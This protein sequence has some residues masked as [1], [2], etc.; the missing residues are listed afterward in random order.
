MLGRDPVGSTAVGPRPLLFLLGLAAF[1][2]LGTASCSRART[3]TGQ[4]AVA[5]VIDGDTVQLVSGEKVRLI[6]VD[7]PETK[8]PQK[9]V[10]RFGRE[11]NDFT[12]RWPVALVL[13]GARPISSHEER[14][15]YRLACRC[16][17]SSTIR[18]Q[19]PSLTRCAPSNGYG[20]ST[21][22]RRA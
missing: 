18:R 21:P 7:T 12:R 15:A 8:H 13:C 9:P 4:R 6:G 22:S 17:R 5:R 16:S 2:A 1:A 14:V 3:S 10:E 19:R 11:A 20:S